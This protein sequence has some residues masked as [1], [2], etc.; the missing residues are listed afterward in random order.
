M[1]CALLGFKTNIGYWKNSNSFLAFVSAAQTVYASA[2]SGAAVVQTR[3]LS[4]TPVIMGSN[5]TVI[6]KCVG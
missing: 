6:N 4:G 1:S 2:C 5:L 3:N